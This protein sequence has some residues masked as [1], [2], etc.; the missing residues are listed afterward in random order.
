MVTDIG[1][2][3]VV[4][5]GNNILLRLD[6]SLLSL[7]THAGDSE[8][9]VHCYTLSV[10]EQYEIERSHEDHRSFSKR[11]VTL[12]TG[13]LEESLLELVATE[14]EPELG[15]EFFIH[16]PVSWLTLNGLFMSWGLVPT[17]FLWGGTTCR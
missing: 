14:L 8:S 2:K 9:P 15:L 13:L 6:G 16:F 1:S 3:S 7:L 10:Y 17:G 12:I 4:S 11:Y 5:K